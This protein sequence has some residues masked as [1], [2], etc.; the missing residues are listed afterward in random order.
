[1][2]MTSHEAQWTGD[3]ARNR[4]VA[5]LNRASGGFDARCEALMR[6]L[7]DAAGLSHAL[8]VCADPS[9]LREKLALA[10]GEADVLV[11]LAGDGTVSTAANLCAGKGPA[12]IPLPGGTMN[13]FSRALYGRCSWPQ[14][15]RKVLSAPSPRVVSGGCAD[16]S[17]FLVSAILGASAR[18]AEVREAVRKGDARTGARLVGEALGHPLGEALSYH[19]GPGIDGVAQAV[20]VRCPLASRSLDPRAT[21]LEAAAIDPRSAM[22]ALELGVN[23]LFGRWRDDPRIVVQTTTTIRI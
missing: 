11:L 23:A 17:L 2:T 16:H 13:V 8:I 15:L 9:D 4:I 20:A 21:L 1:M 19:F 10:I 5:V 3:L 14:I 18:W 12:L 22:E 6:G 7:L